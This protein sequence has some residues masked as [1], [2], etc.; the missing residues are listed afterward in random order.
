[1]PLPRGAY[2]GAVELNGVAAPASS[3]VW[4]VGAATATSSATSTSSIAEHWNGSIWSLST[5]GAGRFD[6]ASADSVSD[7]W[8][9]GYSGYEETSSLPIAWRWNGTAWVKTRPIVTVEPWSEL[10]AVHA[11]A[12]SDVWAVGEYGT[13]QY[14]A[15][16]GLVEHWTGSTWASAWKLP[17]AASLASVAELSPTNVWVFGQAK[18]GVP[19][20]EHYDGSQWAVSPQPVGASHHLTTA[21]AASAT[22]IWTAG[23]VL[24]H[25][26]GSQ[27]SQVSPL[28]G[29]FKSPNALIGF[30]GTDVWLLGENGSYHWD[31]YQLEPLCSFDPNYGYTA[32]AADP[33]GGV[34]ASTTNSPVAQVYASQSET[35]RVQAPEPQ[36]Q[37]GAQIT[38]A[39][40]PVQYNWPV[41][42]SDNDACAAIASFELQQ[43]IDG[44]T[45]TDMPT[46]PTQTSVTLMRSI[47]GFYYP[48]R[49]RTVDGHGHHSSYA[50]GPSITVSQR[51]D[52]ATSISYSSGWHTAMSA[53]ALGGSYHDSITRGARASFSFTGRA[54]ALVAPQGPTSGTATINVDGSP[55][56]VSL[57]QPTSSPRI[58][59]FEQHWPSSSAHKVTITVAGTVG[60]PRVS[61][62]AVEIIG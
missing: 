17:A 43:S 61:L 29:S 8:A 37:L 51:E 31:G 53:S 3:S 39:S 54:F 49:V 25:W 14:V 48:L 44:S 55:Q 47:P 28:G 45:Y 57:Y 19:L 27:W 23:D 6:A 21:Y 16:G 52:T 36:V 15:G 1:M 40:L 59:V 22:D 9:V 32:A 30:G 18:T 2:G 10:T 41:S 12:P 13:T 4:M 62:D 50:V 58:V 20:I 26:N 24:E 46:T 7:V 38:P 11:R 34:W 56:A 35:L 42:G 60:H 33:S 5:V